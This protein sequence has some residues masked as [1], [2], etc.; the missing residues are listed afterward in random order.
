MGLFKRYRIFFTRGARPERDTM[1]KTHRD[2]AMIRSAL[3][4]G[5]SLV[6]V[7]AAQAADAAVPGGEVAFFRS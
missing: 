4:L 2:V 6:F 3:T 5:L 7:P 1:G